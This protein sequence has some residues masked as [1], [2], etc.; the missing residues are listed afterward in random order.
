MMPLTN[1]QRNWCKL[2]ETYDAIDRPTKELMETDELADSGKNLQEDL[3][4][5]G[6]TF[7]RYFE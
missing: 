5:H 3:W 7:Q 1:L 4:T 6:Q 2:M